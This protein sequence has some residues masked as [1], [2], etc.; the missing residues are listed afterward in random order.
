MALHRAGRGPV[1]KTTLNRTTLKTSRLLDY[2]SEKALTLETGHGRDEWPLVILKE[3]LDN[4]LDAAEDAGAAPEIAVKA[5][6]QGIAVEDNGPGIP[7]ETV[8]GVLDFSVRVSSREHYISPTRGRRGTPSRRSWQSP[9]SWTAW[10]GASIST[11]R[12]CSTRSAL[13]WTASA[14]NPPSTTGGNPADEKTEPA[15]PS[16]GR[17]HLAKS[18]LTPN[19]VFYKW[20]A[21]TPS[22][23][24]TL[25]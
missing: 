15:W 3:L 2:C 22:S 20:P 18:S 12:A 19:R 11:R 16:T 5:D 21:T 7:P 17:I 13:P 6:K 4:S 1:V 14:R 8:T 9:T 25:A 10:R 24:P 23:T